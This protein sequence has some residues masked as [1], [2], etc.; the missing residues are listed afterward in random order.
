MKEF[1]NKLSFLGMKKVVLAV[2]LG[3]GFCVQSQQICLEYD[4]AGNQIKRILCIND[5][6]AKEITTVGETS[7]FQKFFFEDTIS[8]YPN[9]VNEELHLKWDL[10]EN[11]VT[12]IEVYNLQ[13]QC[14]ALYNNLAKQN[15]LSIPF[16]TCPVGV[17]HIIFSYSNNQQQ[18]IKVVKR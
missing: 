11:F 12:K 17:Y 15:T 2:C 3:V 9:P 10:S 4:A 5:L 14:V 18:S 6:N 1:E 13:G 8:Y 16:V 7:N